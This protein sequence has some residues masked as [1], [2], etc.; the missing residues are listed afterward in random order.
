MDPLLDGIAAIVDRATESWLG[1]VALTSPI[2][3]GAALWIRSVLLRRRA[4]REF[5]AARRLEFVGIIPS[6]ARLPYK[7]IQ[8]VA[9]AVLLSNVV[10]GQWDGLPIRVFD[11]PWR[12]RGPHLTTILVVVEDTLHR[13]A[14]AEGVL[15]AR[16]E[17][18]IDTDLDILIVTPQRLLDPSELAEWMTFSTTLAKAME[19]D[20]K[21]SLVS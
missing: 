17:A 7:R 21:H 14:L 4:F 1:I 8:R 3:L 16:P 5:A 12:R 19:R 6:D 13:G 10:E 2:W 18:R 20:F 11:M 9:Q 15:A